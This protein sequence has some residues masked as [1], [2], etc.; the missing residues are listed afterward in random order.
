M[1]YK[2]HVQSIAHTAEQGNGTVKN[3]L[4]SRKEA[5]ALPEM[6]QP[7]FFPID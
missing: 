7:V 6:G 4:I 5:A 2:L 1:K 3:G